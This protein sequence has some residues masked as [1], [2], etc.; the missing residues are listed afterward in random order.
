[1]ALKKG[2]G[3]YGL[4]AYDESNGKY[5]DEGNTS[6][7]ERKAMEL[8]GLE[9][10][11]KII[12]DEDYVS[13]DDDDNDE[14]RNDHEYTEEEI[15]EKFYDYYREYDWA[16]DLIM[17]YHKNHDLGFLFSDFEID[18][19]DLIEEILEEA[20]VRYLDEGKEFDSSMR[21]Y[22]VLDPFYEDIEAAL[23]R[24]GLF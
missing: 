21:R 5:T 14:Y 12:N 13:E 11:N 9:E 24:R 7:E 19:E 16:F 20:F 1:M 4:E 2:N 3:G 23:R 15:R 10:E 8:M 6:K 22:E 17:K 18:D